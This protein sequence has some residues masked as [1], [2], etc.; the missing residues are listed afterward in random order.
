MIKNEMK[1][2]ISIFII[3]LLFYIFTVNLCCSIVLDSMCYIADIAHNDLIFH[4]H[5]LI[6]H[7]VFYYWS[8]IILLFGISDLVFAIPTIN[9]LFGSFT[10]VIIYLIFR[11]RFE[12]SK[13]LSLLYLLLPAFSFGFWIVSTSVNVYAAPLTFLILCFYLYL[14]SNDTRRK[15]FW[16][17]IF[18]SIAIMFNQ[19]NVFIFL[20]ITASVILSDNRKIILKK[21]YFYYLI[22]LAIVSAGSYIIIM[23]CVYGVNTLN[24]MYKWI[25]FYSGIYEWSSIGISAVKQAVM[26]I[27]QTISAPYW[28]FQSD[29]FNSIF[30]KTMLG[31]SFEEE[32]YFCRNISSSQATFYLI[33]LLSVLV[34]LAYHSFNLL[35]SIKKTYSTNKKAV[36]YMIFWMTI[37]S[38]MPFFWSGYNQRYWFT[39]TIVFF[40]LLALS[41]KSWNLREKK[42]NAIITLIIVILLFATNFFGIFLNSRSRENDL[43][44]KKIEPIIKTADKGDVVM[45]KKIWTYGYYVSTY[46][47]GVQSV[48]FGFL[49]DKE[50]LLI[51]EREL[52]NIDNTLKKNDIYILEDVFIES[53]YYPIEIRRRLDAIKSKYGKNMKKYN[54]KYVTYYKINTISEK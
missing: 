52:E 18:H 15:W 7:A 22:P 1:S 43:I 29:V 17:G 44:Y 51:A 10:L 11:T 9:A 13:P 50:T 20:I 49:T 47:Y 25:T 28:L 36:I 35:K 12:L 16:I 5:H 45:Y 53:D 33:S 21:Y 6:Y 41:T 34:L 8:K 2:I 30:H 48:N 42:K 26:G 3:S 4:P 27:G 54:Y 14:D 19:W 24:G 37:P 46:M 31:T 39:Q 23:T 38:I 40:M 32:I